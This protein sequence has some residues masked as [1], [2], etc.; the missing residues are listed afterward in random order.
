MRILHLTLNKKWFDM[1]KSGEK[2]EEYREI[3][4]YWEVRLKNKKFDAVQFKNGYSKDAPFFLIELQDIKV[5]CG[6]PAWGAPKNKWVYV[7][8]LGSI[9]PA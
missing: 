7:L 1:I 5:G 3:K 8:K 6:K 4:R 2:K 9:I